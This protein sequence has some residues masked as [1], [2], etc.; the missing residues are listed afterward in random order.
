[1]SNNKYFTKEER[2]LFLELIC[3]KQINMIIVDNT[4]YESYEYKMLEE[5][6]IKVNNLEVKKT[7]ETCACN[8]CASNADSYNP[9][10]NCKICSKTDSLERWMDKSEECFS[11]ER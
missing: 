1:M 6:K 5:L 3:E 2:K 4:K 8:E 7:C 11:K 10:A 9:C